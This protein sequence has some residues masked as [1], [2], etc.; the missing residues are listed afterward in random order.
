MQVRSNFRFQTSWPAW[1][2]LKQLALRSQQDQPNAGYVIL[3]NQYVNQLTYRTGNII[4]TF[5][6]L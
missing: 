3:I 2:R 5:E 6:I 4:S 1:T